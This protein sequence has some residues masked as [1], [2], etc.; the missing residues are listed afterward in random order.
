ML[1]EEIREN[2]FLPAQEEGLPV[3][4]QLRNGFS[5]WINELKHRTELPS[6]RE[7]AHFLGVNRRTLRQ[8]LE[9]FLTSGLLKREGYK[10]FVDHKIGA[11]T[12]NK[13]TETSYSVEETPC[14]KIL[15]FNESPSGNQFWEHII[16]EFNC[17]SPVCKLQPVIFPESNGENPEYW[18][19]IKN[20]E[21]DLAI[22]PV[23][24]HWKKG[25]EEHLLP[26]KDSMKDYLHSEEFLVG[27]LTETSPLL[28]DY[29][30]PYLF[31]FQMAKFRKPYHILNGR[32]I[33]DLSFDEILKYAVES[34]PLEFPLFNIYYDICRDLGAM[35]NVVPEMIRKHC[36]II[37][38]RLDILKK[39]KNLFAVTGFTSKA[40]RPNYADKLFCQHQ[41]SGNL[42]RNRNDKFTETAIFSP[43][44]ESYFWGGCGSIGICRSSEHQQEALLFV[45]FLLS[46][47]VQDM[48]WQYFRS[49]P[50]KVS[51]LSTL[52]VAPAEK[53]LPYLR[54]CRE[55]PKSYPPPVGSV[56]LP[57]FEQY[58]SGK[59][60]R[61]K[62]IETALRFYL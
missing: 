2:Y 40:W 52:D 30:Y 9:P 24:Y 14:I 23:S 56:L 61:E 25:I 39:R 41:F 58:L 33:H 10:T 50:V 55:N 26:V 21:F 17:Q 20:E 8:A 60:S 35:K 1:T 18:E 34:V 54:N 43:R 15:L 28:R 49:A 11:Y 46:E 62:M 5:L 59:I 12:N 37:L 4:L 57:Y 38:N 6:E 53:I 16:T 27:S 13:T 31:T 19:M 7:L 47:P 36:D 45:H 22:L 48:I 29:A 51:S 3:Y 32:S 42:L 44:E